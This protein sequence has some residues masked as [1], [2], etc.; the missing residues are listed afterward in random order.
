MTPF[1]RSMFSTKAELFDFVDR[2]LDDYGNVRQGVDLVRLDAARAWFRDAHE[3]LIDRQGLA[4]APP[5][6]CVH[7][8]VRGHPDEVRRS[9][10]AYDRIGPRCPSGD[11]VGHWSPMEVHVAVGDF[12]AGA[13]HEAAHQVKVKP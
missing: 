5:D 2:S 10:A 4:S 9:H 8:G 11:G 6:I 3:D 7:C 13:R 1:P 12:I